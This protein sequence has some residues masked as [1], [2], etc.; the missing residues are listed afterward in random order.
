M[1]GQGGHFKTW[2]NRTV[3]FE[4]AEEEA[5]TITKTR[6]I[7]VLNK[8]W[9]A[10]GTRH[11]LNLDVQWFQ[12][13]EATLH[14][15]NITMEWL[16]HRFPNQLISRRRKPEWFPYSP[17]L[18]P[19]DVYLWRFLNNVYENHPQSIVELRDH[20][21]ED[22]CTTEKRMRWDDWLRSMN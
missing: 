16:E 5:V 8:L 2:N 19:P 12:Q 11:A 3:W 9:R 14:T 15:S 20:Q 6:Y 22:S 1:H 4:N 10:L 21:S 17:D 13:D 7:D 18:N